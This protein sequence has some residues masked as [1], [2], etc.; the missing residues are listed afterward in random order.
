MVVAEVADEDSLFLYSMTLLVCGG[1][2]VDAVLV[3]NTT[4]HRE[5]F[6][7]S[8][9]HVEDVQDGG[10]KLVEDGEE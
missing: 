8:I 7:D 6:N 3:V 9:T 1:A 5:A 10:V 4:A 2:H